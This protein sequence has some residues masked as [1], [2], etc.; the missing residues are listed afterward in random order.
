MAWL[1]AAGIAEGPLFRP[2]AKGGRVR[3]TRLSD[4]AVASVVK[5]CQA[6]GARRGG[7]QRPQPAQ[8]LPDQ[9]RPP[10][11]LR[12]QDAR[13]VPAQ[14]GQAVF[15]R[16]EP[17]GITARPRQA[18]DEA[19]ADWIGDLDENDR[20]GTRRPS[21]PPRPRRSGPG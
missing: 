13:R 21:T 2:I 17:R 11:R 10:R 19:G 18:V 15:V 12:L 6:P 14:C 4:K 3:S 16:D 8:R 1:E 9:R 20:H 5:A 7:F